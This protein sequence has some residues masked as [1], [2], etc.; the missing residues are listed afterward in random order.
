MLVLSGIVALACI[1]PLSA[2]VEKGD[3]NI[4]LMAN[5]ADI[6]AEAATGDSSATQISGT[7]GQFITD[8]IQVQA[9]LSAM[10]LKVLGTD[11]DVYS[12]AVKSS[13]YFM[14]DNTYSPYLGAQLAWGTLDT[15]G[16]DGDGMIYGPVAGILYELSE[17]NDIFLEYQYDLFTGDLDD[18]LK[19]AHMVSF[20]ISHKFK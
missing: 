11:V 4:E 3:V 1:G 17:T 14:P 19:N 13:Y 7:V 10:L 15:A 5:I 12:V 20:G 8:N 16:G 9:G 2:A 6:S 18:A